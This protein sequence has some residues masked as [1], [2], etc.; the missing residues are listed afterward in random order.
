MELTV[1]LGDY[2]YKTSKYV[3]GEYTEQEWQEIVTQRK[4]WRAE[5]NELEKLL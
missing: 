2:D 1:R 3:D 5:I 4:L